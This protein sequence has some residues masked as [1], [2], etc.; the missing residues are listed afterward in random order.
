MDKQIPSRKKNEIS[1]RSYEILTEQANFNPQDIIIDPNVF[2]VATGLE[3]H[4][5]YAV[6][7]INACKYIT[8][9]LPG[10]KISGGISNVSFSFRG[11]NTVREAMH[12]VFLYH[13]I[14]NGL[15]MGIV[16]AGQ[17][18]VYE[19]IDPILKELVEDVILNRAEDATERL[20]EKA[21]DYLSQDDTSSKN[22]LEWREGSVEERIFMH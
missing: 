4:N 22:N 17:L 6:D 15:S 12:S 20:V 1:K 11:N 21:S 2:A 3:E 19:E 16:N 9:N 7:F 10:A 18:V 8:E 13:A 14:K 5:N